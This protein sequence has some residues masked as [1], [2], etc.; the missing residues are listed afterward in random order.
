MATLTLANPMAIWN[1][2]KYLSFLPATACLAM[3]YSAES[4][5]GEGHAQLFAVLSLILIIVTVPLTHYCMGKRKDHGFYFYHPFIGGNK[6]VL[7]QAIGWAFYS[8]NALLCIVKL[9][10]YSQIVANVTAHIPLSLP[11]TGN[12]V[13]L[14][15]VISS[16][17]YFESES[18]K[19]KE[20][21]P[22]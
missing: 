17:F 8:I 6:Y 11:A 16:F 22:P 7:L 10:V 14:L 18:L 2:V 12:I 13:A 19:E 4:S 15:F 1:K 5:I 9:V 3:A 21:I 20:N